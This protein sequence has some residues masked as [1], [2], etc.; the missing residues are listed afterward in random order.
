MSLPKLEI[1]GG[2]SARDAKILLNGQEVPGL[3]RFELTMTTTDVNRA[4]IEV[5]VG[6]IEIDAEA[7]TELIAAYDPTSGVSTL[8]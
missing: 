2:W 3:T 4:I 6:S 7:V 5:S 8:P 1:K